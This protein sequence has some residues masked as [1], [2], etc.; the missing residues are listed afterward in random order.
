MAIDPTD[1]WAIE[2]GLDPHCE[3]CGERHAGDEDC[4]PEPDWDAMNDDIK[5]MWEGL[6]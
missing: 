2:A 4:A 6:L 1:L 5:L 3:V